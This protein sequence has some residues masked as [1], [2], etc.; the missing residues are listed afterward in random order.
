MTACP[1][2]ATL[3]AMTDAKNALTDLSFEDALSKLEKIV[4][5]LENGSLGLEASI[6]AYEEGVALRQHCESKLKDAQLRVEKLS[7]NAAGQPQ[8][9]DFNLNN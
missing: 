6:K 3:P 7:L 9:E 1:N 2:G 4:Q 5:S 8:R